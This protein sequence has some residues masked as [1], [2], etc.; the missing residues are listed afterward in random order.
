MSDP[1]PVGIVLELRA[2]IGHMA[3]AAGL[4]ARSR[5]QRIAAGRG[6]ASRRTMAA[7]AADMRQMVPPLGIAAG[8]MQAGHMAGHALRIPIG[9]FG[10]ERVHGD[11]MSG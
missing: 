6:V 9:A 5:W 8:G 11:G 2:V 1:G 3:G 4:R 10:A 7:L